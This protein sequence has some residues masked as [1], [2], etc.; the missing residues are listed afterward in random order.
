[1]E[2]WVDEGR[3]LAMDA[4]GA[5]NVAKENE[6]NDLWTWAG[7][8]EGRLGA[9]H[10]WFGN[11]TLEEIEGETENVVTGLQRKLKIDPEDDSEEEE[12]EEDGG[13]EKM[14]DAVKGQK[15]AGVGLGVAKPLPIEDVFRF[16]MTGAEPKR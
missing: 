16:M 3:A 14:P 7:E 11:F 1:M 2:E 13:D 12:E 9:K 4:I 5:D 6:F 8:E 15:A 10:P